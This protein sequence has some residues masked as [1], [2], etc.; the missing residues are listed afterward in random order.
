M[1]K[2]IGYRQIHP[3]A[4]SILSFEHMNIER[5]LEV[6]ARG[7][8]TL[9]TMSKFIFC[10]FKKILNNTYLPHQNKIPIALPASMEMGIDLWGEKKSWIC[11][12]PQE[13]YHQILIPYSYGEI[14]EK[15]NLFSF[16]SRSKILWYTI[17]KRAYTKVHC[18]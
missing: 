10:I 8:T 6:G 13:N 1:P 12:L 17:F 4:F 16:L 14:E 7:M 2:R 18:C 3:K 9:Q 11:I 5:S 15:I